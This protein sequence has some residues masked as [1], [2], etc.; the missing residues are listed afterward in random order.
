MILLASLVFASSPAFEPAREHRWGETL[1][2]SLEIESLN[3]DSQVE[4]GMLAINDDAPPYLRYD[5]AGNSPFEFVALGFNEARLERI[6]YPVH[7]PVSENDTD[8]PATDVP[9]KFLAVRDWLTTYLGEPDTFSTTEK[10]RDAAFED[11]EILLERDAYAFNYTWCAEAANAYLIAQ[12]ELGQ[13]PL[14]VVSVESPE[15]EPDAQDIEAGHACL[16][17]TN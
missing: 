14:L 17:N 9:E 1:E 7:L 4:P 5:L 16:D 3:G 8:K 12:R 11:A 2:E 10:D 15:L 13:A 6:M